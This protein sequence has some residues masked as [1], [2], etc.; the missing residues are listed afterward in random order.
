MNTLISRR[1][2][3]AR[4]VVLGAGGVVFTAT[5]FGSTAALAKVTQK[6]GQ[7]PPID[8][9]FDG[10]LENQPGYS[11]VIPVSQVY[12]SV[13]TAFA[14]GYVLNDPQLC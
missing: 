14:A 4:M 7:V 10:A 13:D 1:D 3:G 2:F 6:W 8:T 5:P 12:R 9:G 11:A